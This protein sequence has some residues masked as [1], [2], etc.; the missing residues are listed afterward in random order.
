MPPGHG[1]LS[2]IAIPLTVLIAVARD[3]KVAAGNLMVGVP[4][5]M[6]AVQ[7]APLHE[8]LPATKAGDWA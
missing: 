7:P 8:I 3:E 1:I 5:S 2:A 4:E 6:R